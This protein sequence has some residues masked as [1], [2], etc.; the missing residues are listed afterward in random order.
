MTFLEVLE[1]GAYPFVDPFHLGLQE[2][3]YPYELLFLE[4]IEGYDLKP[5]Q[6]DKCQLKL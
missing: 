4:P 2:R 5:T 3:R 1:E 6:S